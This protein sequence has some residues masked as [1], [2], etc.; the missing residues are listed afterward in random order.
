MIEVTILKEYKSIKRLS[1]F[2]I[3]DFSVLT[4]KNGS[5]KSHLMELIASK[6]NNFRT[7][8]I[9]GNIASK[10]KYIGFNGLNPQVAEI[11]EYE[12]IVRRRKALWND[13]KQVILEF[14]Q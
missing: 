3:P 2:N 8:L 14:K 10:I 5:G 11:G 1:S 12:D 6:D 7:V 13:I 9:D 4:G